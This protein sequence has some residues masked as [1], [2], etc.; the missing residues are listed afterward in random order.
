M[1]S[2]LL[3][4]ILSPLP[5]SVKRFLT[6]IQFLYFRYC[7]RPYKPLE[8]TKAQSRRQREGFFGKYCTGRGIDIG[9]G[10]DLLTN[11]CCGWDIEH[12][13]AQLLG[14]EK[15]CSY[16]FAYSSHTLEHM[17][18]PVVALQNWWRVVKPGGH[19]ILYIPHRDL[20]EKKKELPSR[21]NLDHK[22]FF[23]LDKDDAPD[24]KSILGLIRTALTGYEIIYAKECSEGHTI[25]EPDVHSDG[26]YS[27]EVVVRKNPEANS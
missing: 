5:A 13:D 19:L 11:D 10:G 17:I 9:Y 12:G 4:K 7:G 20:Y 26:E 27:I 23:L 24:T 16:D 1:F 2:N 3:Y 22:H 18:D 15:D 14:Q 25:T 6:K 21:W 8:S